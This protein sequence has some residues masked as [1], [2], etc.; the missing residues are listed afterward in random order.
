MKQE[1]KLLFFAIVGTLAMP[2]DISTNKT[3]DS[4]RNRRF[5][6]VTVMFEGNPP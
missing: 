5:R 6:R 2:G 3:A 4:E 1:K